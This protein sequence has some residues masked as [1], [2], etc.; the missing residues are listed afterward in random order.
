MLLRAWLPINQPSVIRES[1]P[2]T[3][4]VGFYKAQIP[5]IAAAQ[6]SMELISGKLIANVFSIEGSQLFLYLTI[7]SCL[8]INSDG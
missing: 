8:S 5:A 2:I 3:N 7:I 1:V 6:K 4:G